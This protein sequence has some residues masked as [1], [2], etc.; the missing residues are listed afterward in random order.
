[1]PAKVGYKALDYDAPLEARGVPVV[2][3]AG[4][5]MEAGKTAAAAAIIARMRHRGLIVDAFKA[6]GVSLRRDIMA[7]EDSGAR[8]TM[9]FTDLGIVTTTAKCGPALTRTM[10]TEMAAGQPDAIVF[11][12]GD[13]LL[14]TYGV[15]SILRQPDI[16]AALTA[17]VLSA[18]DPVAAWG[19]VKLLRERFGIEPCAV[20]GPATDNQVGIEIIREQMNVEAFNAISHPADLGDHIIASLRIN[21]VRESKVVGE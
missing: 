10:L 1:V 18:N 9:L 5:C 13:G 8:R 3:L 17:V 4:T 16:K 20:T 2:A 14:G 21:N 12:L 11:E 6:T 7:F 19:G 15:E